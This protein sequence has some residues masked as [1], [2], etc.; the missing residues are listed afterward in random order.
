MRPYSQ[1]A[2]S[3]AC[4]VRVLSQHCPSIEGP[5]QTF[6]ISWCPGVVDFGQL[7]GLRPSGEGFGDRPSGALCTGRQLQAAWQFFCVFYWPA[8]STSCS[9]LI[10][11]RSCFLSPQYLGCFPA[12]P[13][14]GKIHTLQNSQSHFWSMGLLQIITGF[15]VQPHSLWLLA[16]VQEHS[17]GVPTRGEALQACSSTLLTSCREYLLTFQLELE[18]ANKLC[19]TGQV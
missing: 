6:P 5:P 9:P 2:S 11:H 8:I 15:A 13:P 1:L 16:S 14:T 7:I 4:W 3:L 12:P 17:P 19:H 18:R 10:I